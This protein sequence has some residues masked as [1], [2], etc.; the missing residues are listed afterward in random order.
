MD[1]FAFRGDTFYV[2]DYKTGNRMKSQ[3]DA[4]TDRQLAMYAAW[5]KRKYG[6]GKNVKLVWHML[7]FDKEVVSERSN[8][9]LERTIDGVVREIEEIEHCKDWSPRPS[10][11][12]DWCVYR[13]MCPAFIGKDCD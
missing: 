13:H 7:K 4:D 3:Y 2:I 9:E 11:L 10:R 5:V 12:C 1:R 6:I 8:Y